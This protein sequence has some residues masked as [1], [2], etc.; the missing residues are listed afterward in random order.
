VIALTGEERDW[1]EGDG[2]REGSLRKDGRLFLL[3]LPSFSSWT[4]APLKLIGSTL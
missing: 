2:E 4:H 3:Y 1:G